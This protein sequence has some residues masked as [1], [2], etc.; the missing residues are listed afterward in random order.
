MT[1]PRHAI[2]GIGVFLLLVL[3]AC[4][5]RSMAEMKGELALPEGVR[6]ARVV[7]QNGSVAVKAGT[8]RK[9]RYSGGIRRSGATAEILAR[10]EQVPNLLSASAD[11]ADPTLLVITAP[12]IPAD[13]DAMRSILG[14]EFTL[15]LPAEIEV[16]VQVVGIPGGIGSGHL[17]V[18][19]RRAD[20]RMSTG[21]GDMRLENCRGSARLRTGGGMSIVIGH[22]GN[23]DLQSRGGDIQAFLRQAADDILLATGQGNVQCHVPRETGFRLD[24]RTEMGKLANGFGLPMERVQDYG[25]VMRGTHGDGRT[26]IV[27]RSAS[28]HLSM[29][30]TVPRP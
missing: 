7:V 11:P 29:T 9:I 17:V 16:D 6:T 30:H 25:G 27:L 1:L 22:E 2:G 10:L 24:A 26:R 3:P 19:D 13:A 18:S 23:L 8:E 28:G 5:H 12:A 14:C 20:V 15:V 21:R 4:S